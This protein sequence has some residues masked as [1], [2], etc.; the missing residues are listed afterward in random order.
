[1]VTRLAAHYP[2]SGHTAQTL[3]VV[4]E[5]WYATFKDRLS[6]SAF[7]A[8]VTAARRKCKFFPTEKDLLEIRDRMNL[9]GTCR[10][11][12]EPPYLRK[13]P[14]CWEKRN[15]DLEDCRYYQ[16]HQGASL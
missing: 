5:D 4:A 14:F 3:K 6:N 8:V 2:S 9:C 16:P 7:I 10:I 15:E 13:P 12:H 1:M 11:Y